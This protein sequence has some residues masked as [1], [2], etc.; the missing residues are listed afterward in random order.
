MRH[1][2]LAIPLMFALI[3]LAQA[4]TSGVSVISV[5][6]TKDANDSSWEGTLSNEM[7]VTAGALN[8][9]SKDRSYEAVNYVGAAY[10]WGGKNKIGLR[11]YFTLSHDADKGTHNRT[12]DDA[13]VTYSRKDMAGVLGSKE[14]SPGVRYYLPTSEQSQSLHSHGVFRADLQLDWTLTPQWEISYSFTPRQYFIPEGESLDDSGA[15]KAIFA[16]TRLTH[17]GLLTY[18]INDSYSAY[19]YCGFDH[20]WRTSRV[21]LTDEDLLLGLGM[22]FYFFDGKIYLNPEISVTSPRFADAAKAANEPVLQEKNISYVLT[23]E[24]RF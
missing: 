4:Q 6:A 2:L 19:T 1:V 23:S 9:N 20:S 3:S 15:A 13:V 22:E 24:F 17:Y 5:D 8:Y 16:K 18:C 12:M 7:T 14:L 21:S 11:Q 10:K